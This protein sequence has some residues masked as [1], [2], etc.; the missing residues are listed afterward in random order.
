MTLRKPDEIVDFWTRELAPEDWYRQDD[1]LDARIREGFYDSWTR[2][3]G[4]RDRW[5]AT[6]QGALALLILTDQMPRNMFRGEA[7]AFAT[8]GLARGVTKSAIARGL[9]VQ[10]EGPAR[11]F[12]YL[13]LEHSEAMPD[14]EQAV[15][16]I[17]TRM[18]SAET[19]LHARAHRDIIRR[20]GRFPFRNEVLGRTS[21]PAER[22]FLDD[23]GYGATVRALRDEG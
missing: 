2:A 10:V 12:F 21:S 23:G 20:F 11:Q 18:E 1:A 19:L 13:P 17:A 22:A 15:R 3:R 6:A 9:D 4:L 5:P 7:R 16:L 14:Q 8:D